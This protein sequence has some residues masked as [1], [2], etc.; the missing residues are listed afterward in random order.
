MNYFEKQEKY[1]NDVKMFESV[2]WID[3]KESIPL[4]YK[5]V[6]VHS[7]GEV[8]CGYFHETMILKRRYVDTGLR[9]IKKPMCYREYFE[10]KRFSSVDFDE[11]IR[12]DVDNIKMLYPMATV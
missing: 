1:A 5:C 12:V 10:D 8:T 3:M 6:F 7:D 9:V 4:D 11:Y 2:G